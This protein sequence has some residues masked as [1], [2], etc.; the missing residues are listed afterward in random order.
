M[1]SVEARCSNSRWAAKSSTTWFG[2][3]V[4]K[5]AQIGQTF[6]NKVDTM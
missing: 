4:G 3:P 1:S 2:S 6:K 5:H